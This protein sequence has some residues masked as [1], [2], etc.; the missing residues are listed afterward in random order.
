MSDIEVDGAEFSEFLAS[1]VCKTCG[2]P[3]PSTDHDM[4]YAYG[5]LAI[6]DVTD[7]E[8]TTSNQSIARVRVCFPFMW[9]EEIGATS[10]I[11]KETLRSCGS[12]TS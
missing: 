4:F 10:F 7:A 12:S 5:H 2:S 9:H 1:S 6:G 3:E 11:G 8:N